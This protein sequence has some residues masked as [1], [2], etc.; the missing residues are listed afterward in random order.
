MNPI[1]EEIRITLQSLAHQK[2]QET[3][4]RFF[5]EGEAAKVYGVRMPLVNNLAK[6]T[7]KLLRGLDKNSIFD[8]CEELWKSAY[9]EEAIIAC[10]WSESLRK[11]YEEDDIKRFEYWIDTYVNNWADCDTFCNHTVG[12]YMMKFPHQLKILK[13]WA[14]SKKR[15]VR[16]AAAV[17]LIVP[18][19][20][21]HFLNEIFELADI[22][23][24]DS[25][26]LV[27]KGYGWLLKSASQAHPEMVFNYV[28]KNKHNMPRT[29][30]RYAIEKLPADMKIE[31]MKKSI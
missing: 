28:M 5:K 20:K 8:L 25:D 18:A 6:D 2:N 17:S 7:F 13:R 11:S 30:L 15:F 12:N 21:G 26:D 22:L 10:I 14:G 19:K 23:L 16:R 4:S 24:V 9:L 27:Q 29:A 3:S 1:I 31:A